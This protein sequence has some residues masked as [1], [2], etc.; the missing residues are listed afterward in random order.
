M[1]DEQKIIEVMKK[2]EHWERTTV[3][4]WLCRIPERQ[5]GVASKLDVEV[6]FV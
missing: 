2:R 1:F 3:A 4:D 5:R 6:A